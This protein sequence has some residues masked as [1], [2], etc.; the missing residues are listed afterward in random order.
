MK[1]RYLLAASDPIILVEEYTLRVEHGIHYDGH[2]FRRS[3]YGSFL[4][5][6]EIQ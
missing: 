4:P 6:S 5:G 3:Q 2:S 1:V